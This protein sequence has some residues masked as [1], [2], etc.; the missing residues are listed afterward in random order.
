LRHHRMGRTGLY[1]SELAL[2]TM[3]F[4]K[5]ADVETADR[6]V[7]TYLDAGGTVVDTADSYAGGLAEE[8]LG[9]LLADRRD[10]VVLCSKVRFAT[11]AGPNDRGASRRHILDSVHRSLRRLRTDRIDVYFIHCWDWHTPVEETVST[12]DSLVRSGK[13]RYIGASNFAGWQTAHAIGVAERMGWEPFTVLQPQYSLASRSAERE[14]LPLSEHLGLGVIAWS[15]L[16]GGLLSGKYPPV[17][18]IDGAAVPEGTRAAD[19]ARRGSRTMRDRFTPQNLAVVEV[20]QELSAAHGVPVPQIAIGWVRRRPSVSSILLGA[21]TA[22][23]L[24][25]NL[26]VLAVELPDDAWQRLDE[27]SA[28]APEYPYDFLEYAK[29][30]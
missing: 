30:V 18:F 11:G 24:R 1:L 21:R 3:T 15:P 10:E 16:G 7:G 20:L 23:Q 5:E 13:V 22:D 6:I 17:S 25:E 29:T 28:L 4:G 27:I 26:E 2:G 14:L 9:R 19:A 8:Y 12:L